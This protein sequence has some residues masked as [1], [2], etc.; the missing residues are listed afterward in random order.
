M[1]WIIIPPTTSTHSCKAS[2]LMEYG[3]DITRIITKNKVLSILQDSEHYHIKIN[4]IP[5]WCGKDDPMTIQMVHEELWTYIPEYKNMKQWRAPQW[6]GSDETIHTKNFASIVVD[7]TNKHDRDILLDIS[8]TQLFNYNC[9]LT[10]YK[11][12][13]HTFQC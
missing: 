9:T 4:K 5:T 8:C 7:M 2:D 3:H 13:P 6:L 12:K 1:W 11:Y 10:P